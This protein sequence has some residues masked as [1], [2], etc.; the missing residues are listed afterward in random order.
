M[1]DFFQKINQVKFASDRWENANLFMPLGAKILL[2]WP[3][4]R[5]KKEKIRLEIDWKVRIQSLAFR[6]TIYHR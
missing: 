3:I 6:F 2:I 1:K 5:R 4:K